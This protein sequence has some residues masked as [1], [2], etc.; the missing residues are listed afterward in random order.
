MIKSVVELTEKELHGKRILL[1]VDFNVPV[2]NGKILDDYKIMAHKETIDYLISRGAVV[3]LLSHI[4]SI[5]PTLQ[6]KGGVKSFEPLLG[7]IQE[8]LKTKNFSLFENIRN[9][10]GEENND[11]EFAEEIAKSFD[12]YIND[13]FSV[14]HRSH[15]SIVAITKFMPSYAGLLLMKEVENLDKAMKL[16][17]EGKTL[18]IGGA[19]AETKLPIIESFIDKSENILVGGVVANVFLKASGVDIKKSLT[20][21][22]LLDNAKKIIANSNIIIP[23]DYIFLNDM[24]LDVGPETVNKFSE[25]IKKSKVVIWNGPLGKAEDEDSS[26][27]TKAI[28][29]AIANSGAFSVIGGGDTVAFTIKNN[30]TDKFSYVS[31]GGGAML[32]FL[33]GKKMPGLEVLNYYDF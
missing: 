25:I 10:K 24:I 1:R 7:Q 31:T 18:I 32:Y 16:P 14:S 20:D 3:T 28:A 17:K 23:K 13:A 9:Y 29:E 6:L 22:N 27:G 8:I 21:D 19:K 4:T 11:E 26:R 30:L 2:E 15:V 12:I 5:D 33:S